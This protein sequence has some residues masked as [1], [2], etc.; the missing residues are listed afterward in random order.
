MVLNV[1]SSEPITTPAIGVGD[2]TCD[3]AGGGASANNVAGVVTVIKAGTHFAI[4]LANTE[5]VLEVAKTGAGDICTIAASE[6]VDRGGL[7]P[8]AA[9]TATLATDTKAPVV[10]VSAVNCAADASAAITAGGTTFTATN[11]KAQDGAAGNSYRL[12][13]VNS[14]GLQSPSF[15]VDDTA[16]TIVVTADVG[17]HTPNDLIAY[18][19]STGAGGNWTITAGAALLT[20]TVVAG[21]SLA[22]DSNCTMTLSS[23]E[24]ITLNTTGVTV[25][26]AGLNAGYI[27]T[28]AV[29][30]SGS[31]AAATANSGGLMSRTI[32]FDTK[33]LGA[34]SIAWAA[35][36][37]GISDQNGNNVLLPNTFTA[38]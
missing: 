13:V 32:T 31:Y 10:S 23:N 12:S 7:S 28:V 15:V 30:G 35:G 24:P 38:G 36:A 34:G 18:Q 26:V 6:F 3:L 2:L 11:G 5:S 21:S 16:K 4:S 1:V 33:I 37:T 27:S 20:A 17:Y 14:R 25:S 8:A 29:T 19:T 22:G 9:V